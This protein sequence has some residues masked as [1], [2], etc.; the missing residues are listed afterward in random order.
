MEVPSESGD[1]RDPMWPPSPDLSP[2]AAGLLDKAGLTP[3]L[4]YSYD[5]QPVFPV[6]ISSL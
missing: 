2:N 5:Q 1:P 4:M 6:Y 3:G